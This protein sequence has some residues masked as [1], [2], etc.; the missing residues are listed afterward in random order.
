MSCEN[1]SNDSYPWPFGNLSDTV[2]DLRAVV[3]WGEAIDIIMGA[4]F[5]TA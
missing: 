3:G 1:R 2:A 4:Y 5:I